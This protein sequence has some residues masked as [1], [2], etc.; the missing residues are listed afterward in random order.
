MGQETEYSR[1]RSGKRLEIERLELQARGFRDSISKEISLLQIKKGTPVLDAG[2]G[3]GSFSRIIAEIVSPAKVKAIDIEPV[4]IEEG[5]KIAEAKGIKNIEFE[6]GDIEHLQCPQGTFDV[7]Y[8]GL[9]LPHVKDARKAI[10][11]LQRV[12]RKGGL[13]ASSD[14]AGLFTFPPIE[15]FFGLFAKIAQ[16]RKAT[17]T[18]NE[19]STAN[20]KQDAISLFA[21]IGLENLRVFPIPDYAS[22]QENSS[23]LRDLATVLIM[24]LEIYKD[25]VMSKGFMTQREYDEGMSE[26]QQ[27]LPRPDSFWMVLRTLTIGTVA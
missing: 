21:S 7:S 5:R 25:E 22:S 6:V 13:I 9:V 14:Q 16:W 23:K 27:W 2:C 3:I 18:R 24:M 10:S 11:E 1:L 12:T 26:L 4:F 8:I 19:E 17:E 20:V 15:K